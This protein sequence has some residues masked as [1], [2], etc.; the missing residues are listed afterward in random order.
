MRDRVMLLADADLRV[1]ALAEFARHHESEHARDVRL[2][3]SSREIEL[4]VYV[5]LKICR[6]PNRSIGR[7]GAGRIPSLRLLNPTLNLADIVQISC[8]PRPI[9][10]PERTL[11][12]L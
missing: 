3:R 9:L 11:Q 12:I 4:Q 7:R 10:Y 1:S 2:K 6:R 8:K 5:V